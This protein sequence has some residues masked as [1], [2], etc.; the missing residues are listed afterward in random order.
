MCC[1]HHVCLCDAH[2]KGALNTWGPQYIGLWDGAGLCGSGHQRGFLTER[3]GMVLAHSNFLR[4]EVTCDKPH[5]RQRRFR[6]CDPRSNS[7]QTQWLYFGKQGPPARGG[8]GSG[9][10][11][12]KDGCSQCLEKPLAPAVP[13]PAAACAT[14]WGLKP[15][16]LP[17]GCWLIALMP[18]R[19]AAHHL[20]RGWSPSSIPLAVTPRAADAGWLASV[21]ASTD[22][23]DI[24][25]GWEPGT[26]GRGKGLA[27][28]SSHVHLQFSLSISFQSGYSHVSY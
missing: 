19:A 2:A 5:T 11:L 20:L 16:W 9:R 14:F 1:S 25:L 18:V 17:A 24:I 15:A 26:G 21:M 10:Q 13:L 28:L 27:H 8:G 7:V 3:D 6:P 4:T 22:R 23:D 12:K